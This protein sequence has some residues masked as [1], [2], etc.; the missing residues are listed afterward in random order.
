MGQGMAEMAVLKAPGSACPTPTG[1]DFDILS[2][3]EDLTQLEVSSLFSLFIPS[4]HHS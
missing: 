1:S 4:S 2:R 3:F